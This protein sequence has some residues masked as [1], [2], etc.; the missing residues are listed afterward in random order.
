MWPPQNRRNGGGGRCARTRARAL[1]N[2]TFTHPLIGQNCIYIFWGFGFDNGLC[3]CLCVCVWACLC[4][5][6]VTEYKKKGTRNR[7]GK[8]VAGISHASARVPGHGPAP[9]CNNKS[10]FYIPGRNKIGR[11]GPEVSLGPKML[12]TA[13]CV[14]VCVCVCVRVCVVRL[15][16]CVYLPYLLLPP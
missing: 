9:N 1:Q 10:A 6:H 5:V 13:V 4:D 14:C 3:V 16:V 8:I 7:G 2:G 12:G 11:A 15:W